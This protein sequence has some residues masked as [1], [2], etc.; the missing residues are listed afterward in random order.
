MSWVSWSSSKPEEPK[1]TVPEEPFLLKFQKKAAIRKQAEDDKKKEE[2][3]KEEPDYL[4]WIA[5]VHPENLLSGIL[6]GVYEKVDILD[7]IMNIKDAQVFRI[8]YENSELSKIVENTK[9]LSRYVESQG[10]KLIISNT[11]NKY[12]IRVPN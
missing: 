12:L 7:E 10:L 1:P 2:L 4:R 5:E 9:F 8:D 3:L 6:S 11:Y